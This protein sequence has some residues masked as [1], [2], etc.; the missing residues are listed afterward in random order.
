MEICPQA[1]GHNMKKF[2]SEPFILQIINMT[3]SVRKALYGYCGLGT[4]SYDC[5]KIL[6]IV[7]TDKGLCYS[8]NMQGYNT[9]FNKGVLS[10]DFDF[11]R[12]K[13][14]AKS[15]NLNYEAVDDD[16]ETIHWTMQ[17]GYMSDEINII[18]YRA[19]VQM[20]RFLQGFPNE[21]FFKCFGNFFHVS[22]HSPSEI[23]NPYSVHTFAELSKLTYIKFVVNS[24]Q[25]S[26]NMQNYSPEI[27]KCYFDGEKLLKFFKSYT[28]AHCDFECLTNYTKL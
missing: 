22:I 2:K 24:L 10:D 7:P 9:I 12:L 13:K 4:T 1:N 19:S 17:D 27:R 23:P 14:I 26:K 15:L 20:L 16:N 25:R 5:D 21:N 3:I 18:P 6:N 28:K 8:F 11:Y